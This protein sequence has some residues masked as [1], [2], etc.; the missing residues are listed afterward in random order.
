M[1][2]RPPRMASAKAM[3]VYLQFLRSNLC[4]TSQWEGVMIQYL[5]LMILA[6]WHTGIAESIL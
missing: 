4:T 1:Q 6:Y 5:Y 3:T 2:S